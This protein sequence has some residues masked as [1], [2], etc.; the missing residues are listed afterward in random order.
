MRQKGFTLLELVMALGVI[1]I[2]AAIA[3]PALVGQRE[4]SKNIGTL[5]QANSVITEIIH[6][7]A[8]GISGATIIDNIRG[9]GP[10]P[11]P[12]FI[13][14]KNPWD[15]AVPAFVVGTASAPG[16]IGMAAGTMTD[17]DGSQPPAI[18]V[19]YMTRSSGTNTV[20]TTPI[21]LN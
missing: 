8:F 14:A 7:K 3:I 12:S 16:Q 1:L 21:K 13:Q 11:V 20:V 17:S 6:Q 15:P 19:T 18:I 2:L 4:K 5:K 10:T 9:T